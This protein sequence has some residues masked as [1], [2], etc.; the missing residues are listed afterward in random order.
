MK[1]GRYA[2]RLFFADRSGKSAGDRLQDISI[3]GNTVVRDFD[4][5]QSA[6]GSLRGVVREFRDVAIDGQFTLE[7]SAKR[8][9]TLISGVELILAN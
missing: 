1:P 6:G 3:Q 5:A 8:G 9:D 7:L 4:I 2:V